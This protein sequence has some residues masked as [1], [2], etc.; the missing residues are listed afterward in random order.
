MTYEQLRVV[1]DDDVSWELFADMAS[2]FARAAVPAAI[3]QAL[4]HLRA[5]RPF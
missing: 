3:M 4:R 5:S 2:D 1:L